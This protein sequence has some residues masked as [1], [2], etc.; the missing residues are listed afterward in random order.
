[1]SIHNANL[2]EFTKIF[3]EKNTIKIDTTRAIPAPTTLKQTAKIALEQKLGHILKLY[4]AV[5]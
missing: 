5:V 2:Y 3:G 4:E 1:V